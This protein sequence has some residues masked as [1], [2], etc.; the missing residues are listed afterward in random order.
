MFSHERSLVKR[1]EGKPFVLLGVDVGDD[2]DQ[3]QS[4]LTRGIVTWRSWWDESG[5]IARRWGVEMFPGIFLID[6][7]GVIRHVG[8][9]GR[10]LDRAID[11]LVAEAE[12]Q[13]AS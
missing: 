5:T 12:K 11:R 6:S 2:R 3:V 7:K 8:L 13:E 9:H 10:D 1:L 4:Q